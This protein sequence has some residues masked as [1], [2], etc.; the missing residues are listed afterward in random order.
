M[1]SLRVFLSYLTFLSALLAT[2][3][4]WL[5][6]ATAK[7]QNALF[8]AESLYNFFEHFNVVKQKNSKLQSCRSHRELQFSYKNHLHPTS[9]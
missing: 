9:Y 6:K 8:D 7:D 2:T 3:V 5:S 1:S 4:S